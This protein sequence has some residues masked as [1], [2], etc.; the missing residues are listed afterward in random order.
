MES[1][2]PY[3]LLSQLFWSS[4]QTYWPL[5][6]SQ[7]DSWPPVI[8]RWL[9][10]CWPSDCP[11]SVLLLFVVSWAVCSCST[12]LFIHLSTRWSPARQS[13]PKSNTASFCRREAFAAAQSEL[14][15][16]AFPGTS[17]GSLSWHS[18]FIR[19]FCLYLARQP[20]F[21][22]YCQELFFLDPFNAVPGYL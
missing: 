18:P 10:W 1:C 8:C 17:F 14:I 13:R 3:F 15:F 16:P 2:H 20:I 6:Y 21:E 9:L 22:V 5:I 11:W 7:G 19:L 4:G 12:H